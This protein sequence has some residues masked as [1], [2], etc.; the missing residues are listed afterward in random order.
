VNGLDRAA[1]TVEV[2]AVQAERNPDEWS[3]FLFLMG[4]GGVPPFLFRCP[5]T[6]YRVQGF[7]T[8]EAE[9]DQT[10]QPIDCIV[11]KRVHLVNSATGEVAGE[12]DNE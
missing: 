2:L 9:G 1:L 5:N 7:V 4:V 3:G 6:G 11:C 12:S 10:Y 8:E